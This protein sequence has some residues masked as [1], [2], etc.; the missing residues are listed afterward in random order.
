MNQNEADLY[1]G[2][3]KDLT[4]TLTMQTLI[5][6]LKAPIPHL[7]ARIKERGRAFEI[8]H[9]TR[10]Y[11][12]GLEETLTKLVKDLHKKSTKII[13][14]IWRSVSPRSTPYP[15]GSRTP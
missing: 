3:Y 11:L 1:N 10:R 5:I 13:E 6:Y 9:H 12:T 15:T 4:S 2:L 14:I 8:R 7:L